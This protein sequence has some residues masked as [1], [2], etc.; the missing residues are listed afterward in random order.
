V[1]G[2][3]FSREGCAE[4]PRLKRE[5]AFH[6]AISKRS[7]ETDITAAWVNAVLNG[8]T[9]EANTL[10][11]RG[12]PIFVT[13]DI[14]AM[15]SWLRAKAKGSRRS[16]LIASSGAAR[17]RADGVETPTFSWEELTM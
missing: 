10:A 11:S 5:A 17:L 14:E 2:S 13:R 9:D 16:G 6:L 15:R 3:P 8:E 7:Y 1:A 4:V 12:L